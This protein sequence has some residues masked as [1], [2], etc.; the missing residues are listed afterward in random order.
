MI[1][2]L[3]SNWK[4]VG[5]AA[6]ALAFAY[7]LHML[8]VSWLEVLHARALKQQ[9]ANLRAECLAQ[10][11]ITREVSD[12]YQKQISSLNNQLRRLKR[13]PK[14][15][16]PIP[17][18]PRGRHGTALVGEY[19]GSYGVTSDALY[20]FAGDAEQYRIQLKACQSFIIKA[21]NK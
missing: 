19:G 4:Y 17:N 20:D 7:V 10:Q 12:D 14:H 3:I 9:E 2:F 21:S 6:A 13:L 1:G 11:T 8:S 5:V 16:V 15:C 18:S